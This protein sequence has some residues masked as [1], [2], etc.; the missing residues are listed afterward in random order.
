MASNIERIDFNRSILYPSC[1][2]CL[3]RGQCLMGGIE[4]GQLEQFEDVIERPTPLESGQQLFSSADAFRAIFIIRSGSLKTLRLVGD[5]NYQ[6]MG[7]HLPGEIVGLDGIGTQRHR[8]EAIA[9]ERASVCAIP[10]RALERAVE[11]FPLLQHQL[12]LIINRE[13]SHFESHLMA[14]SGQTA[15]ERLALFLQDL[16]QRRSH[17]GQSGITFRVPLSRGEIAN[18]LGLALETVSRLFN[19]FAREGLVA[20]DHRELR[21]CDPEGLGRLAGQDEWTSP[22]NLDQAISAH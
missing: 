14:L 8:I 16:A 17:S 18:Y 21:I 15:R 19:Q 12:H 10:I 22:A 20:F 11:N 5:S 6:I 4:P 9:L 3:L 13:M 7:F 1:V 2:H